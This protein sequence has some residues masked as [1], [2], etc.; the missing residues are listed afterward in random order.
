LKKLI[1]TLLK[2][3][4]SVGII[5]YLIVDAVRDE[6]GRRA[7]AEIWERGELQWGFIAAAW[8]VA[9][10]AVLVTLVR[11]CYLVRALGIPLRMRDALRTGLLGYLYNLA[12]L[13]IVGGDLLKAVML[14]RE[15]P[16]NRAKAAASVIVDRVVGLYVLFVV[17]TAGILLTGFCD[18]AVPRVYAV[19]VAVIALTAVST[20]VV[21]FLL[22]ASSGTPLAFLA[23]V[24]RIGPP[25]HC[26]MEDM[27]LY[28]HSLPTL[29]LSAAMSVG[30]HV[31]F[32]TSIYCVARGLDI[33]SVPL[34]PYFAVCPT[35][36][37]ASTVPLPAGPLEGALVFFFT[38]GL[39]V[40]KI[41][42]VIV[43]LVFRVLSVS[44]A[45]VGFCYYL[46][47]R[48]EVAEVMQEVEAGPADDGPAWAS[49]PEGHAEA[50]EAVS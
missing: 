40:V 15:H 18:S 17:A 3:V 24:P 48:R 8:G 38:E 26:L 12:P 34:A 23:R 22:R 1:L 4:T 5:A 6:E 42:A 45:A 9:A 49:S 14:A 29:A 7:F 44:I 41:K 16:G 36:S 47:S 19:C 11:W 33:T 2:V 32:A 31:L 43:A 46:G 21:V 30:V 25:V 50:A 39:Q 35:S 37:I 13:G 20:L 10:L 27:R 28:Q